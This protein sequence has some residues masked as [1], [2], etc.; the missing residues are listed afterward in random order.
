MVAR[1]STEMLAV[2]L[3]ITAMATAQLKYKGWIAAAE[4]KLEEV[5]VKITRTTTLS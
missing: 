5:A 2:V 3:E 4:S 1:L